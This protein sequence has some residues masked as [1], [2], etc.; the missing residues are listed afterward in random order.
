MKILLYNV[1]G[2]YGN[3]IAACLNLYAGNKLVNYNA[4]LK[5]FDFISYSDDPIFLFDHALREDTEKTVFVNVKNNFI[6]YLASMMCRTAGLDYSL[7]TFHNNIQ[8]KIVKHPILC[9][10]ET[11]LIQTCSLRDGNITIG[12]L[13]EW[14]R[15]LFIQNNYVTLHLMIDGMIKDVVVDYQINFDSIY[16]IDAFSEDCK[17]TLR[18][19]DIP[20]IGDDNEIRIIL[21]NFLNVLKYHHTKEPWHIVKCLEDNCD[22]NINLNIIEEA[23]LDDYLVNKYNISPLLQD[24]YPLTVGEL[25]TIYKI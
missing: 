15:L 20:I 11:S 23:W 3:L 14:I 13:R 2:S 8:E 10:F 1:S 24:N 19:F 16:N 21:N 7:E 6:N 22:S 25:K 5:I 12:E 9:F 17:K 18:Y 4:S